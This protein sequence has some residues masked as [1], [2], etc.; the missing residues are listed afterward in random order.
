[1]PWS[2][3][4]DGLRIWTPNAGR[5]TQ[6]LSSPAYEALYGGAAGG[7]KSEALLMGSLRGVHLPTYRALL[8]RR[9]F[10][11]LER[12]LI[13]RSVECYGG[14]PN[15][16]YNQAMTVLEDAF[17]GLKPVDT[18]CREFTSEV[19]ALLTSEVF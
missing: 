8:L 2:D 4:E 9:T 5:Q 17:L 1:M 14:L 13:P 19:N 11:E 6:F 3:G 7:G 18:A 12:S 10:K 16:E 15:A